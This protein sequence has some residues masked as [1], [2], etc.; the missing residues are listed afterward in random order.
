[1][2]LSQLAKL[3]FLNLCVTKVQSVHKFRAEIVK[4]IAGLFRRYCLCETFA[5]SISFYVQFFMK[6]GS[7]PLSC[8]KYYELIALLLQN[9]LQVCRKTN[10]TPFTHTQLL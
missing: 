9:V 1:M 3:F 5:F 2:F 7:I 8:H 4:H 6:K 10:L